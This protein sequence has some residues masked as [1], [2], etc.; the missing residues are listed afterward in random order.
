MGQAQSD[1]ERLLDGDELQEILFQQNSLESLEGDPVGSLARHIGAWEAVGC[2]PLVLQWID[3]GTPMLFRAN[4]AP[5]SEGGRPNYV[6]QAAMDFANR[7]IARLLATRAIEPDPGGGPGYIFPIGAVPKPHKANE[8]RLITDL[9][10]GGRG[11]NAFMEKL[12]FK[13]EHIDDLLSQIGK[14]WHAITFD[15]RAGFHHL[16]VREEDRHWLRFRWAGQLFRFRVLP[17]GPRHSPFFF[18]KTVRQFVKF[19]RGGCQVENCNHDDCKFAAAPQ[20]LILVA[21]VDDF[22]V[23]ARS[24]AEL[25]KIRDLIITPLLKEFGWTRAHD[26]GQWEPS[27]VF[28]FLGLQVDTVKGTVEIPEEKLRLYT[29]Q[30]DALLKLEKVTPRMLASVA[31]RICSVMRA[32]A[33]A[34]IYLRTTFRLVAA[35]VDGKNGWST[36]IEMNQQVRDDLVWIRDHLRSRNG[37]FAWRPAGLVLLHTD[38][39][40]DDGSG[41][42]AT[43]RIGKQLWFAQGRWS[44]QEAHLPI[45]LLEMQ[46]ILLA[47]KS[48]R[49]KLQGHNIQV[50]TDNQICKHTLPAG[51][52]VDDILVM[53][54]EIHD[55][56]CSLDSTLVDVLWIPSEAN[57]IPDYLSRY[58]D[59]NDW[60]LGPEK[61]SLVQQTWPGLEVDRFASGCDN[62]KLERFNTRWAHPTTEG[63]NALAQVWT[64]TFS[65]ACPPL[66]MIGRVLSL[67]SEQR[68]RAVVIVPQWEQQTWWPSLNRIAVKRVYLGTGREAFQVGAGGCCAPHK[69]P[70]WKFWAVEVDASILI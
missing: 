5:L 48:F 3:E 43:L 41:W 36:S 50:T 20:G 30:I 19:L 65:Y 27:Q 26:K 60:T 46:A 2:S 62:A 40:K 16:L 6:P 24:R 17:F 58:L 51:S 35:N 9:T 13:L 49:T 21:Y 42:G 14:G 54:K 57:V 37:R 69:N 52:R 18:A 59:Q 63:Y 70:N 47:V 8:W 15:L 29:A 64:G 10:D 22:C 38:A 44:Q 23:C 12:S 56:I 66:A 1:K 67:I 55:L 68:A 31:G 33:P 53:V 11:P 4:E 45:H 61:W 32:F 28:Q 25:I 7:E 39:S 34:L